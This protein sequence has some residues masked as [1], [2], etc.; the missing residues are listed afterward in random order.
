MPMNRQVKRPSR[1][2][3]YDVWIVERMRYPTDQPTDRLTDRPTDTASYRGALSHLKRPA[4]RAKTVG[5]AL[6]ILLPTLFSLT[7]N[8]VQK[9]IEAQIWRKK[10][11]TNI[12][13]SCL[14]IGGMIKIF[15]LF[16]F[17]ANKQ[18]A[19]NKNCDCIIIIVLHLNSIC[20]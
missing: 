5:L 4:A 9:N 16:L 8:L 15:F 14:T 17:Q 19:V 6:I 18:S 10:I 2:I 3:K 11:R 7:K 13:T 20:T 1:P 12:R